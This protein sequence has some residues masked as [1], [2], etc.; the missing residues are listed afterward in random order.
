MLADL[1]EDGREVSIVYEQVDL[2]AA[3]A[4]GVDCEALGD[5]IPG[6]EDRLEHASPVQL[7]VVAHHDWMTAARPSNAECGEKLLLAEQEGASQ[8]E[9]PAGLDKLRCGVAVG[10]SHRRVRTAASARTPLRVR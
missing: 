2:L 10:L 7:G 4:I 5:A 1:E 9:L 3:L 8:V 6:G